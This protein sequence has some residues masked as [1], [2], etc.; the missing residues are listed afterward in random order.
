[1][2]GCIAGAQNKYES[3][4][5]EN[6]CKYFFHTHLGGRRTNIAGDAFRCKPEEEKQ[7]EFTE[8]KIRR[9]RSKKF[10]SHKFFNESVSTYLELHSLLPRLIF[11]SSSYSVLRGRKIADMTQQK[12]LY[13]SLSPSLIPGPCLLFCVALKFRLL[14][15]RDV[16]VADGA[17]LESV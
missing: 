1:M 9:E 13:L 14:S 6:S 3:R 17:R 16:R 12:F 8:E 10:F 4:D 15:W 5:K 11:F 2:L 7:E